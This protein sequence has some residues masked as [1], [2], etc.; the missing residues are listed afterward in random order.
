MVLHLGGELG[1]GL[2]VGPD[3]LDRVGA[4]DSRNR[5]LDVVLDVLRK[6]KDDARQFA[7]EIGVDFLGQLVLGHARGPLIEG[8]ERREKLDIGEGRRIAAVVGP[9]ML[10]GDRDDLRI[11]H[12]NQAHFSG[13]RFAVLQR[14]RARHGSANPEV[15]FLERGQEFTS[16]LRSEK[17]RYHEENKSDHRHGGA[18]RQGKTQRGMVDA[19]QA[20]DDEGFGFLD[21]VGQE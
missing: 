15:A 3:D 4:F 19:V 5:L 17:P 9:A 12:E 21:L 16:Q 7:F 11:F 20:P 10:G 2:Q 18:A 6:V 1:Q 8:L 14:K 13:R